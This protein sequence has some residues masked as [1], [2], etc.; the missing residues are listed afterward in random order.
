M[1]HERL[2]KAL[3]S[4]WDNGCVIYREHFSTGKTRIQIFNP[5]WELLH[6]DWYTTGA[7]NQHCEVIE[8]T[9][10]QWLGVSNVG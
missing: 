5:F 3:D 8:S 4:V 9:M 10:K 2:G 1:A 7:T 6:E